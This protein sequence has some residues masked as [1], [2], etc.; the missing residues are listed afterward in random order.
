LGR[1]EI[2][3][4]RNKASGWRSFE[5]SSALVVGTLIVVLL[6]LQLPFLTEVY[7]ITVD[8]PWYSQ[9]AHSIAIG[10]GVR[11]EVVGSGGGDHFF[12]YPL[13]LSAVFKV[14]G[15]SFYAGRLCSVLFGLIALIG[16]WRVLYRLG[17]GWIEVSLC[18]IA[19]IVSNLSYIAFRVIRPECAATAFAIWGTYFLLEALRSR[20]LASGALCGLAVGAAFLSHPALA[21]FVMLVGIALL[22]DAVRSRAYSAVTAY[23]GVGLGVLSALLVFMQVYHDAGISGNLAIMGRRAADIHG[24]GIGLLSSTFN[25]AANF[26]G[27]LYFGGKR[28]PILLLEI[29]VVGWGLANL[30]RLGRSSIMPLIPLGFFAVAFVALRPMLV[31]SFV[32]F[33]WMV[34]A[35][36]GLLIAELARTGVAWKVHA[37]RAAIILLILNSLAGD[38]LLIKREYDTMPYSELSHE[39]ETVVPS[40]STVYSH[41]FLWF[42]LQESKMYSAHTRW[43]QQEGHAS[44][45]ELLDS[46]E[47]DYVILLDRDNFVRLLHGSTGT[48][49]GSIWPI[50]KRDFLYNWVEQTGVLISEI[51]AKGYGSI[52]IWRV[53]QR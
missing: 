46:G 41:M 33:E 10:H 24:G 3:A 39:I 47:V 31:R 9:T 49:E 1:N 14:A 2:T 12:L 30:R 29:F 15:T 37:A 48:G 13:L 35:T 16:L 5:P 28:A 6:S 11:N 43:W 40:G 45:Y 51:S 52:S 42:P 18:G 26:F 34:F 7:R 53:D 50:R 17:L 27:R 36:F 38:L 8:E 4:L 32:T 20:S 19:F 23:A 44:L 22:V 21:V 25:N